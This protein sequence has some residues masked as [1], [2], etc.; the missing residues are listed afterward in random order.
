M[1]DFTQLLV[2][3]CQLL[4][5]LFRLTNPMVLVLCSSVRE[6]LPCPIVSFSSLLTMLALALQ[7]VSGYHALLCFE[8]A[9]TPV[10]NSS[11]SEWLPWL[12][13]FQAC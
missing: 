9:E 2:C 10:F 6:W 5:R 3:K 7:R 8:P 13:A 11:E 12:T 1:L 4:L